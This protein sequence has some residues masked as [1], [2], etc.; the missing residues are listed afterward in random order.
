MQNL[1]ELLLTRQLKPSRV[2]RSTYAVE[3][4]IYKLLTKP[5]VGILRENV[6]F[7]AR[8]WAVVGYCSSSRP[9]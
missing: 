5:C 6:R 2:R 1:T 7:C 3:C 8:V 4:V 9:L